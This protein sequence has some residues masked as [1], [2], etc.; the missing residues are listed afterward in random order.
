MG[1][2]GEAIYIPPTPCTA[3]DTTGAGDA[4][5]AGVLYSVLRGSSDLKSMGML[6][7][8]VASVVVA[9]QGTRLRVC[10]ARSLAESFAHSFECSG[11]GSDLGSDLSTF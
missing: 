9:Q 7:S 1:L 3:V 6:A 8:R 5:A 4:Y 2:Q 11:A 10:D